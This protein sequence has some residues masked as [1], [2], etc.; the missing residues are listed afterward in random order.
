MN[1]FNAH[2][3]KDIMKDSK[4]VSPLVAFRRTVIYQKLDKP[5]II[6]WFNKHI[7]RDDYGN[8]ETKSELIED[9]FNCSQKDEPIKYERPIKKFYGCE[10]PRPKLDGKTYSN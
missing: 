7:H 4:T 2:Q 5:E 1:T 8:K 10:P 3:F 9:M 6:K